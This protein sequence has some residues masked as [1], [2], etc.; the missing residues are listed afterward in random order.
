MSCHVHYLYGVKLG[1]KKEPSIL[2]ETNSDSYIVHCI[3]QRFSTKH[4]QVSIEMYFSIIF[5]YSDLF[6]CRF[7]DM[8]KSLII[9]TISPRWCQN[10]DNAFTTCLSTYKCLLIEGVVTTW[11]FTPLWIL[12]NQTWIKKI[13]IPLNPSCFSI[14]VH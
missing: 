8:E 14:K 1:G 9:I 7:Q 12:Q 3:F 10:Y 11:R 4:N 6:T 2:Y 5:K 13:Y